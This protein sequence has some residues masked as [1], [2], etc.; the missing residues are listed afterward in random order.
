MGGTG[1][2]Y[3]NAGDWNGSAGGGN[4]S[5]TSTGPGGGG[6]YYGGGGGSWGVGYGDP[7]YGGGG[8]SSYLHP[9]ATGEMQQGLNTVVE[10]YVAPYGQADQAGLIVIEY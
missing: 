8:G 1:V 10:Q 2:K 4:Y 9:D 7:A 5:D 3:I 6:G